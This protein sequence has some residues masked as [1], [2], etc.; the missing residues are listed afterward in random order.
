M[1]YKGQKFGKCTF[2]AVFAH[3]H[4]LKVLPVYCGNISYDVVTALTHCKSVSFPLCLVLSTHTHT[5]TS[6]I[7][8]LFPVILAMTASI[9]FYL[10]VSTSRMLRMTGCRPLPDALFPIYW[11]P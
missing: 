1:G 5:H 7:S 6:Q 2:S 9:H 4:S 10:Y 8:T 11:V 3:L